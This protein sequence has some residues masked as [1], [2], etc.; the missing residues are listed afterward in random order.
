MEETLSPGQLTKRGPTPAQWQA[1]KDT[2]WNL[3]RVENKTHRE[4]AQHLSQTF[5]CRVTYVHIEYLEW[6]LILSQ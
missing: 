2:I 3:F 4:L 6:L 1:Q 5:G